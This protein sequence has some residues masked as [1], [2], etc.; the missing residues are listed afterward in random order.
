MDIESNY[1]YDDGAEEWIEIVIHK[2]PGRYAHISD[3]EKEKK[4][5]TINAH[6]LKSIEYE[7][8]T[9]CNEC[10]WGIK[11][12]ENTFPIYCSCIY[13]LRHTQQ[14]QPFFAAL[15]EKI[16]EFFKLWWPLKN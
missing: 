14:H 12:M 13:G 11:S 7:N 5:A 1:L 6:G 3:E 4:W 15:G 10:V 9:G 8:P 16:V 2:D